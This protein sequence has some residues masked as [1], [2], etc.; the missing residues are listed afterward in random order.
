MAD[1]K[2]NYVQKKTGDK[3]AGKDE[4]DKKK[5]NFKI[6]LPVVIV[7][8]STL[9]FY[10]MGAMVVNFIFKNQEQ[11]LAKIKEKL[12]IK[13]KEF[14]KQ[15]LEYAMNP[16]SVN[17]PAEDEGMKQLEIAI[18]FQ[19][20]S[21]YG[22]REFAKKEDQIRDD[23][24]MLLSS[25]NESELREI[26]NRKRLQLEIADRVNKFL[27]PQAQIKDVFFPDFLIE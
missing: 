19:V 2:V 25:K 21:V 6:S 23:I 13:K 10:G 16:M 5:F 12:E 18:A 26:Q 15:D 17:I 4:G 9:F 20:Q 8:F 24:I 7:I 14:E 22:K 27:G 3:N 1:L 11:Q